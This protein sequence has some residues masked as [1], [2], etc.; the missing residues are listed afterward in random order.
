MEC[1]C[2]CGGFPLGV[3][4]DVVGVALWLGDGELVSGEFLWSRVFGPSCSFPSCLR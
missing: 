2:V 3:P 4:A 1:L